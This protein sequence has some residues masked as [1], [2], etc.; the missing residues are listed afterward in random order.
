MA[1]RKGGAKKPGGAVGRPGTDADVTGNGKDKK[2]N[3]APAA[4]PEHVVEN[5]DNTV[6][7][8]SSLVDG[9]L[10]GDICVRK[11]GRWIKKIGQPRIGP[12]AGQNSA[13]RD[14]EQDQ[15]EVISGPGPEIPGPR[16][17]DEYVWKVNKWV[18]LKQQLP[19][20]AGDFGEDEI[21]TDI[22][23][24]SDLGGG[25]GRP[26]DQD[27]VTG[28]EPVQP[29]PDDHAEQDT[30]T[31][32]V[33]KAKTATQNKPAAGIKGGKDTRKKGGKAPAQATKRRDGAGSMGGESS[34]PA[35]CHRPQRKKGKCLQH[36][37]SQITHSAGEF[38]C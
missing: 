5:P 38:F 33:E 21:V 25:E 11:G 15:E 34:Y 36:M 19:A 16:E 6:S 31:T 20:K 13:V 4:A 37:L 35:M 29:N 22:D 18:E 12:K 17:V 32:N 2:K 28:H 26:R 7:E 3:I 14:G 10:H 1:P 9:P 8:P 27:D 23:S 24:E 30:T